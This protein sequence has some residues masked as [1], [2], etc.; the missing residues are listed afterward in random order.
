MA[1]ETL[2]AAAEEAIDALVTAYLAKQGLTDE[3]EDV[4]PVD[5]D[6]ALDY[7]N[8]LDDCLMDPECLNLPAGKHSAAC[9]EWWWKQ[10]Q[11][12]KT[13]ATGVSSFGKSFTYSKCRHEQKPYT[14]S[15]GTVILCSSHHYRDADQE[16]DLACYLDGIWKP[17]TVAFHLGWRD[18]GLPEMSMEKV[19]II[20][21]ELLAAARSGKRVEIGCIG[22][23]GR[24][25]TFLAIL[26]LLTQPE[27][28]RDAEATMKR[29]W[30]DYCGQAIES[31]DQEWYIAMWAAELDGKP[32]PPQPVK[33]KP[34]PAPIK[35][36]PEPK[37]QP[38]PKGSKA[39]RKAKR[40][41]KNRK[42]GTSRYNNN[43]RGGKR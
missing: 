28:E 22:G 29:I 35:M 34:A 36:L 2:G 6:A 41:Q 4:D 27:G 16:P 43:P 32:I 15:D 13:A 20:A 40:K 7:G 5:V 42:A 12:D 26:D 8:D 37:A 1:E 3:F 10:D 21:D 14:L 30:A 17:R 24:T 19:R 25:G 31:K 18:Y 9:N 33:P 39:A 23:H 11:D 38:A